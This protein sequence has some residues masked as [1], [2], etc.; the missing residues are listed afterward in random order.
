MNTFKLT[1]VLCTLACI[2]IPGVARSADDNSDSSGEQLLAGQIERRIQ[3]A[4][5]ISS[6]HLLA[7]LTADE[8]MAQHKFGLARHTVR[9]AQQGLHSRRDDIPESIFA[10]LDA[11]GLGKLQTIDKQELIF[12]RKRVAAERA[13]R[14]EAARKVPQT[15]AASA[16][17]L[18]PPAPPAPSKATAPPRPAPTPQLSPP[19]LRSVRRGLKTRMS[20]VQYRDKSFAD[21]LDELRSRSG[22]NIVANWQ[23]L[24]NLGIDETTPLSLNLR[25]VSAGLVLKLMLQ[26]LS[27]PYARVSY[28][29]QDEVV[30][31]AAAEELDMIFE[32]QVYEIADLLMETKEKRG[33]PQFSPGGYN[34]Q[35]SDRQRPNNSPRSR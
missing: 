7:R 33:G 11:L 27:S 1:L 28:I 6:Q 21:A 26:N 12:L 32:L 19:A 35:R 24:A 17:Q 10:F 5:E 30:F 2:C 31:I 15:S 13:R 14:A 3:L 29:I 25:N 8:L 22:I 4:Q 18:L 34:R 20:I 9:R 16:T 23:S